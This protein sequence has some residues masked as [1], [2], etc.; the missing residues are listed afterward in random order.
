MVD[1]FQQCRVQ[2][3]VAGGERSDVWSE[4]DR[5]PSGVWGPGWF[6]SR[7]WKK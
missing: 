7:V 5:D 3:P 4:L 2:A 1:Q 6:C